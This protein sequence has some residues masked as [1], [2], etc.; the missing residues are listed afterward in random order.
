[1]ACNGKA[2]VM[3][4]VA[5]DELYAHGH[6]RQGVR[7]AD[8]AVSPKADRAGNVRTEQGQAFTCGARA[9]AQD[10]IHAKVSACCSKL[11]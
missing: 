7:R 4:F 8:C 5:L 3:A 1:M 6:K 11:L 9:E 10:K 2:R